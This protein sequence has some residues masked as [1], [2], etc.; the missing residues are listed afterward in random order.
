MGVFRVSFGRNITDDTATDVNG[1]MT[2]GSCR[3]LYIISSKKTG[4]ATL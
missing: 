4:I 1:D 3:Y 2:I